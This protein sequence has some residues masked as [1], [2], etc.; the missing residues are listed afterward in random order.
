VKLTQSLSVWKLQ[1]FLYTRSGTYKKGIT[2]QESIQNVSEP[3][4]EKNRGRNSPAFESTAMEIQGCL[5][6]MLQSNVVKLTVTSYM[7]L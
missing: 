6:V 1:Y 5:E 4:P 7:F 2:C 3:L